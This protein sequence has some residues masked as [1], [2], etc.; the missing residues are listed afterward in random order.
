MRLKPKCGYIFCRILVNGVVRSMPRYGTKQQRLYVLKRDHY[1]CRYCGAKVT[2]RTAN[3][4]HVRPFRHGGT[5]SVD[6]LVACC[7]AC[8]KAKG[9][10]ILPQVKQPKTHP[11]ASRWRGPPH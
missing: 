5:T 11:W 10:N 3:L 9:N 2:M 7:R 6:N 8:N 1:Q 4:D